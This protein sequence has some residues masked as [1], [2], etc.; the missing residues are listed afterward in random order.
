MAMQGMM[1]LQPDR[2]HDWAGVEDLHYKTV[3]EWM[4]KNCVDAA[5]ALIA[6]LNK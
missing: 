5:D 1:S 2:L 3:G 4:A 6:E